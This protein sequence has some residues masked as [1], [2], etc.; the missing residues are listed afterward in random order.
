MKVIVAGGRDFFDEERMAFELEQLYK[1]GKLGE[2][3]ELLCG[4]ARGADLLAKAIFEAATEALAKVGCTKGKIPHQMCCA[5]RKF[6]Q[7]VQCTKCG[8]L[9]RFVE[10]I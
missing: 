7:V 1:A 8:K 2:K 6:I 9:K 3:P 5:D 10:N 4:M